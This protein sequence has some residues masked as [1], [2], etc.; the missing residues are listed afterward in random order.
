MFIPERK[1]ARTCASD[2][3]EVVFFKFFEHASLNL[4]KLVGNQKSKEGVV[5]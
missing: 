4:D 1:G 2:L 3:E 5:V